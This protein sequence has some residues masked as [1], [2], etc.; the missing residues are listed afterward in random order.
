V[1]VIRYDDPAAFRRDGASV[2]LA[3]AARNNLPLG[4]LQVL[5]DHPEVYPV[6]HLWMAV[7]DGKPV[8]LA[9]QT[10]PYNLSL[11][12]KRLPGFSAGSRNPLASG[13]RTTG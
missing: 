1:E 8:G 3:D 7:H 12:C 10:E 6:F 5:Q 13:I 4:V 9:L 2:L 11:S